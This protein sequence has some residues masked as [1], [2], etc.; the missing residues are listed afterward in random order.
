MISSFFLDVQKRNKGHI[1]LDGGSNDLLDAE[2]KRSTRKILI[3]IH[4][5]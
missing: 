3:L 2:K 1:K 5:S 4:G